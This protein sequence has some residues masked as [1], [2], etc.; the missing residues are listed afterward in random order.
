M[1]SQKKSLTSA[2]RLFSYWLNWGGK[3][4]IRTPGPSQVNGFQDRRNRPLCHLSYFLTGNYATKSPL[5]RKSVQRY[6]IF[7]KYTNIVCL[8]A[9]FFSR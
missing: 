3:R 6:I 8:C 2:V 4:G 9:Y 5:C 1:H 7:M